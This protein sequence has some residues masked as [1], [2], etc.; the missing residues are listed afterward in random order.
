MLR[1]TTQKGGK[2][3][4]SEK[5][6]LKNKGRELRGK[7]KE[8][9]GEDSG[10]PSLAR[11]GRTERRKASLKQAGEKVKEAFKRR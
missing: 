11:E 3:S 10:S 6:K 8:V 4:M 5:D 7:S 9:L 1:P 2:E